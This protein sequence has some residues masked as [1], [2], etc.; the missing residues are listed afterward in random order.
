MTDVRKIDVPLPNGAHLPIGF[1]TESG[2]WRYRCD[3]CGKLSD[4]QPTDEL[5]RERAH[6]EGFFSL[7]VPTKKG[8]LSLM[9]CGVHIPPIGFVVQKDDRYLRDDLVPQGDGSAVAVRSWIEDRDLAL[10]F[11]PATLPN[12]EA[13]AKEEGATVVPFRRAELGQYA[14]PIFRRFVLELGRSE[15]MIAAIVE[16]HEAPTLPPPAP[17]MSSSDEQ[18]ELELGQVDE[19][20]DTDPPAPQADDFPEAIELAVPVEK[21]E[22]D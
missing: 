5:A 10:H 18:I 11:V 7:I 22:S 16:I 14:R 1:E 12:A 8:P 4:P 15:R 2:L 9:L 19:K 6:T 13:Y 3:G 20:H 21:G 17:P